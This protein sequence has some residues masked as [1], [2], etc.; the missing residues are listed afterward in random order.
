[1]VV[2]DMPKKIDQHGS[3]VG[4]DQITG[5]K[6]INTKNT[7]TVEIEKSL[8]TAIAPIRLYGE[9]TD[10]ND[11]A[12]TV[13]QRKLRTGGFNRNSVDLAIRRKAEYLKL[14]IEYSNSQEGR[15]VLKDIQENLLTII[16]TKYI[17]HMNEGDTLR[18]NLKD[19]IAEFTVITDKFKGLIPID[20]AF[21]EG[22]LYAA[23]SEC[24][25]NWKIE[26]FEDDN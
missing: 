11:P 2:I 14:Q 18:A 23:T 3:T 1:M 21:V 15:A 8:S 22:I 16:N 24:A 12:N 26:G 5:D 4:G 25:I 20:E 10:D 7:Y 13:L 19:I 17:A 6:I 9:N